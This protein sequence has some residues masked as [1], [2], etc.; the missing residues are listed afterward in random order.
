MKGILL[1]LALTA[2]VSTPMAAQVQEAAPPNTLTAEE[3]A[4]GWRLLFDGKT[5]D[6]W[7]NFKK[8][9][10][11][12]GWQ[13]TPDG[14]LTRTGPGGD[15]VTVDQFES[16]ELAFDWKVAPGGNSGVM[17][18]ATEELDAPWH[19]GP[20]YQILDNSGH[21]DGAKKETS[22]AS[23][24]ALHAPAK[25]V[26]KPAGSWNQSRIVVDGKHVEHWL[27]GEKVVEYELESPEWTELV[28]KSKFAKYPQFGRASRGHIVLQD[29]GDTVAYRNIRIRVKK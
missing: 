3:R 17:F 15:I 13:V 11:P 6:G 16:F 20:E 8:T 23:N 27:N 12:V 22:T 29:H 19:T 21:A 24:Y 28:K 1:T 9:G 26:S 7:R 2:L 10:T 14:A 25:D 5:T 4:S 18:R